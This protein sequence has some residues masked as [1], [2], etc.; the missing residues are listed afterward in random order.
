MEFHVI[1]LPKLPDTVQEGGNSI[2]SWAK[3]INAEQ[4]E[5]FEMLA[6]QSAYLASAYKQLQVISQDEQKRMEYT[7]RLK[8]QLDHNQMMFEVEERG[9]KKGR[10]EGIAQG[11]AKGRVDKQIENIRNM[12]K[13]MGVSIERAMSVL[14]V[15]EDERQK[16]KDLLEQETPKK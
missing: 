11:M 12:V 16:Y 13:N 15:P 10:A 14:E 7:A 9:I 5:E 6:Q 1:E 8:E 3:F 4:K 2:L